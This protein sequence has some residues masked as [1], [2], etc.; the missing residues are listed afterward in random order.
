MQAIFSR[1]LQSSWE[2][3]YNITGRKR[4]VREKIV[5]LR[6]YY[7]IAGNQLTQFNIKHMCVLPCMHAHTHAHMYTLT[8]VYYVLQPSLLS[9]AERSLSFWGEEKLTW[10]LVFHLILP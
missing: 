7:F 2:K 3:N 6:L 5:S 8:N 10:K 4:A 1:V 9:V